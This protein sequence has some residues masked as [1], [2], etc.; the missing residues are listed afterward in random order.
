MRPY[1]N[2]RA[3]T[4]PGNP[5]TMPTIS[6]GLKECRDVRTAPPLASPLCCFSRRGG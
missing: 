3:A 1:S 5:D 2:F 4:V 6:H